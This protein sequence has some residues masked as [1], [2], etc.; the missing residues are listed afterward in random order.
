MKRAFC[1]LI[2]TLIA[3]G[4]SS[5]AC[6]ANLDDALNGSTLGKAVS[7]GLTY[8]SPGYDGTGQ[9]ACFASGKADYIKYDASYFGASGTI[10]L[11]VK[12]G[13]YQTWTTVF[14]TCPANTP[15][16]Q[17]TIGDMRIQING[18]NRLEFIMWNGTS[19]TTPLTYGSALSTSGWDH[20]VVNYGVGGMKLY[21]NA[22]PAL[23]NAVT[24]TRPIEDVFFGDIPGDNATQGFVG[25]IDRIKTSDVASASVP[26][27]G[28]ILSLLVG[29]G[30]SG[31]FII[32]RRK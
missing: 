4:L 26:E 19:W 16:V 29:L 31:A 32:R 24:I 2:L 17:R 21:V 28:S 7:A 12:S 11:Y 30:G 18:A 25:Y 27:P 1:I 23:S 20:V 9:A 14:D 13:G 22:N 10:D 6:A 3:A 15:S 8:V 5:F